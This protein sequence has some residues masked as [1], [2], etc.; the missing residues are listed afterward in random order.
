MN[1]L[2]YIESIQQPVATPLF[3]VSGA[4][5]SVHNIIGHNV[6]KAA[7]RQ[8]KC[9]FV[10]DNTLNTY[11]NFIGG[12]KVVDAIGGELSLCDNLLD[13]STLKNISRLRA[14]LADVGF[15]SESTMKLVQYLCFVKETEHRMGNDSPL[16]VGTLEE[17]G[18]A[19][20]VERKLKTLVNEGRLS[21]ANYEYLL[22][23]YSEVSAAAADFENFLILIAPFLGNSPPARRTAIHFPFADFREDPPMQA[24][25]A[26]VLI[27]YAKENP[28]GVALILLDDGNGDRSFLISILKGIPDIEVHMFTRDAFTFDDLSLSVILNR[29]PIR[30]YSR[31]QNM[32]SC[33]S[34]EK[35]CEQVDVIKE[36]FST[37]V[38]RRFRNNSAWDML[39]GT[40]R[41]ETVVRN[42]PTKEYRFRKEAINKL[43]AGTCIIDY[44]GFRVPFQ[45]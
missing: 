6:L 40:N 26:K 20:L 27:Y 22:G 19:A 15:S 13:V 36:S 21:I 2:Q 12:H 14:L 16:S 11:H 35:Q 30:F 44:M 43:G 25:M 29:L 7:F 34:V 38:D 31:H 45:L 39:L 1:Y 5:A 9:V 41:T 18:G 4:D 28:D 10:V 37:T 3:L 8:D 32:N 17:Y 23:R 42:A 33:A 24:I